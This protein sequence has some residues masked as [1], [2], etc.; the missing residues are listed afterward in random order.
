MIGLVDSES[1]NE[2]Y[3]F[4]YLGEADE[5]K[6]CSLRLP[7]HHNFEC[8]RRYAVKS[9]REKTHP[10]RLFNQLIVCEVEEVG[11]DVFLP[12][13]SAFEGASITFKPLSCKKRL[14]KHSP[15]C[16]PEGL[17][18]GD[19]CMVHSIKGKFKCPEKGELSVVTIRRL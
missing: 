17:S 13:G 1:A 6:N 16:M 11:I 10:C 18:D 5:C 9:V 2:G 19:R 4:V 8:G 3:E 12:Q 7:C 15:Y 14:C